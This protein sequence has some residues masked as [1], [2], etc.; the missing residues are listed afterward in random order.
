MNVVLEA[1]RI[2]KYFPG[3]QALNNIDI[4]LEA[5]QVHCIVGENGAGKSTLIK[6]LTGVYEPEAGEVFIDGENAF[7]NRKLF[8]KVAYVPQEID[9]FKYMTVAENLFI[10]YEKSGFKGAVNKKKINQRAEEVIERFR[11][12]VSPN[13]H[14]QDIS[15]SQQQSLQIARAIM[16]DEYKVLILDEP[17]T[18][19]STVDTEFLFTMIKKL[20]EEQKSIVFISHKLEEVFELGNVLTILRN[21]ASVGYAKVSEIDEPY[22]ISQMTGKKMLQQEKYFS[23]KIKSEVL[24]SVEN[25]TGE[26]FRN[27]SFE[28]KKG[29][30]LGFSGL[31]GSGRSELMQAIFGYR[32][33]VSG[34]ILMEGTDWKLGDTTYSMDRGMV[35][36]PEE[37]RQ[38]GILPMM[39]VRDNLTITLLNKIKGER[40]SKNKIDET[41]WKIISDYD[42]KTPTLE[43]EI[44]FLSGGNQQKAIIGR[45]M[46]CDPKVLI[47][48]EPTK[49]IDVR[50]KEAIYI[51]MKKLAEENEIG[52]ILISSEMEEILKC[53]NRVVTMYRGK[54]V[55]EFTDLRN[56][57]RIMRS[58]LGLEN[59]ES[60]VFA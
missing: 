36:L 14:V 4:T 49:G 19:L 30:I 5:G 9:L 55:G 46:N 24:L 28:L 25:L 43:K 10:P 29:E 38:Q 58:I 26:S 60:E 45:S 33:I 13:D 27:I 47:F 50:T 40:L 3:V 18:S 39:S 11:L 23:E 20:C 31:V 32:P 16:N 21:G 41:S 12:N 34:K 57:G 17:T 52:I 48:D 59:E 35:Y 1:R 56:Q 6:C 7:K 44:R 37:R 53:S 8:E 51:L 22:V 54:K 42:V 2:S 15:V